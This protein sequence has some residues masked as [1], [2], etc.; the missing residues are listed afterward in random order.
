MILRVL[1]AL[2][3]FFIFFS[4]NLLED[5]IFCNDRSFK[6]NDNGNTNYVIYSKSGWN[7]NGGSLSKMISFGSRNRFSS[8]WYSTT[9]VPKLTCPNKTDRFSVNSTVAHLNYPIGLLTVDELILAGLR[10]SAA[11]NDKNDFYLRMGDN[12]WSLSPSDFSQNSASELAPNPFGSP[13]STSTK[14][15]NGSGI[16]PVVSL[17]LGTEF[18]TGGDGTPTNPYV[19]KYE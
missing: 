8:S 16:R 19:V 12:F 6:I 18:E 13:I 4:S 10:G 1:N 7:P 9:N 2:I 5:T 17:K 14:Y 3:D 15:V 11:A